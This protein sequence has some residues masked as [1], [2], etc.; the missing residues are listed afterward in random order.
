MSAVKSSTCLFFTRYI[1]ENIKTFIGHA[2][3][4][5]FQFVL[6]TVIIVGDHGVMKFKKKLYF[7]LTYLKLSQKPLEL[8]T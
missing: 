7:F 2:C 4:H 3:F 1:I 5:K 6:A 8:F